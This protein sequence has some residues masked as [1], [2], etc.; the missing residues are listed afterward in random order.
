MAIRAGKGMVMPE[1][2]L[3]Q[4][5]EEAVVSKLVDILLAEGVWLSVEETEDA[6]G[7]TQN[8]Q[9]IMNQLGSTDSDKL[10]VFS[11]STVASTL[12][13]V[14]LVYG[15]DGYDVISN[16]SFNRSVYAKFE[17]LISGIDTESFTI[18]LV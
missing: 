7:R 16:Y 1:V 18:T 11:T 4:A 15:N 8:K 12:G 13:T 10:K 17:A 6:H 2:A 3:R 5:M 9:S 14:F